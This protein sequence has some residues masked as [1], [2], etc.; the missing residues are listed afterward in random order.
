MKLG[1]LCQYELQERKDN[2][3]LVEDTKAYFDLEEGS[4]K[5][6]FKV[7]RN[8]AISIDSK[9]VQFMVKNNK[10]RKEVDEFLK[11]YKHDV[12]AKD[13]DGLVAKLVKF[14]KRLFL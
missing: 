9:K 3:G 14:I 12:I 10:G 8:I 7:S 13:N 2:V 5:G 1:E 6:F 4:D 11:L